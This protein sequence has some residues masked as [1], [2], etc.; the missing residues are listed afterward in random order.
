[1]R[2]PCDVSYT[3]NA[4]LAFKAALLLAEEMCLLTLACPGL[5]TGAGQMPVAKAAQ[6][7]RLAY[8]HY[9]LPPKYNNLR[10]AF[11][12]DTEIRYAITKN[13]NTN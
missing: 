3:A 11:D 2:V 6:Q 8:D 12:A 1:M 4:Y 7:M 9:I 13:N 5:A 10:E